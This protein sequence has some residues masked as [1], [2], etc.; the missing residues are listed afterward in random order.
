MKKTVGIHKTWPK[1]TNLNQFPNQRQNKPLAQGFEFHLRCRSPTTLGEG[2]QQS[3]CSLGSETPS[4][5]QA[6]PASGP[7]L[8]LR[9]TP[10][11]E[12]SISRLS[13]APC[14]THS[15]GEGVGREEPRELPAHRAHTQKLPAPGPPSL[16]P[17]H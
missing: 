11:H 8:S 12:D 14:F 9:C 15:L 7:A 2:E 6:Q 3:L 4:K 13:S 16:S 10:S 17:S 5:H 1:F